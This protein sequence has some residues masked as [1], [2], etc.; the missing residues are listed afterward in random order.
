MLM[1][2]A[3]YVDGSLDHVISTGGRNLK[4]RDSRFLI[5]F[6]MTT[7]REMTKG[8]RKEVN[9]IWLNTF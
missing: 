2:E 9:G 6:G 8:K 3:L 5:P 7:E 4:G 1:L